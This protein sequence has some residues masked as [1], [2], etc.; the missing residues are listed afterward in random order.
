[1]HRR[2]G[3]PDN[4]SHRG[5]PLCEYCDQRYLD[6]DELFRHLRKEHYFCHFCD[7]DGSNQF[8]AD[9]TDLRDHFIEQ[10]FLCEDGDC[11]ENIFSAVFRSD[12]DLKAHK[13]NVHGQTSK[14]ARTIEF[15]FNLAPRNRSN[16]QQDEAASVP[17]IRPTTSVTSNPTR[18]IIDARN[19]QEF[20]SLGGNAPINIRPTVTL[21]MRPSSSGLARTKENFPAL[22]GG[23]GLQT[24]E[25]FKPPSSSKTTTSLFK[26]PSRAP[27]ANAASSKSSSTNKAKTAPVKSEFDFPSLPAGQLSSRQQ[28]RANLERDMIE[29]PLSFNPSLVSAKHRLL[30]QS[31]EPTASTANMLANQKIKTIQ[32]TETKTQSP[33]NESVPSIKSKDNF[34]ALGGPTASAAVAPQWLNGTSGNSKK[35]KQMSKKLKVAPAPILPTSKSNENSKKDDENKKSKSKANQNDKKKET[36]KVEN[37]NEKNSNSKKDKAKKS[38]DSGTKATKENNEKNNNGK[39]NERKLVDLSVTSKPE[40]NGGSTSLNGIINSYSS[41]AHFTMP[42]PGFPV[43]KN[44]NHSKVP[45]GFESLSKDSKKSYMS[46]SNALQRNQVSVELFVRCNLSGIELN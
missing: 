5:H 31:Y 14:Q 24:R 33:T 11:K 36:A 2:K 4:K 32:R 34:P 37:S 35:E 26:T 46:P 43:K 8:Y 17:E 10:H 41:V 12:I 7:A 28:H 21:N 13:A 9:H 40:Q 44:E 19:E 3:D 18:K 45:P 25:P 42:P 6:R 22:G 39:K 15:Q 29:T 16:Q 30:V 38:E 23:G 1:M 27:A 20:P